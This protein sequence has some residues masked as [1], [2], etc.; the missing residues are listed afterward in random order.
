VPGF[1]LQ[2]PATPLSLEQQV[3]QAEEAAERARLSRANE[4]PA[5]S[6]SRSD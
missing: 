6:T 1:M 3:R 4:Q 2:Q 5:D